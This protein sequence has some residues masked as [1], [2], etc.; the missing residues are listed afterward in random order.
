MKFRFLIPLVIILVVGGL[1]TLQNQRKQPID[2]LKQTP[3]GVSDGITGTSSVPVVLGERHGVRTR[4]LRNAKPIDAIIDSPT[5]EIPPIPLTANQK[6]KPTISPEDYLFLEPEKPSPPRYVALTLGNKTIQ[7][8]YAY[9]LRKQIK[10]LSG[11]E[12]LDVNSGLFYAFPSEGSYYF[13]MRGMLFSID[14]IWIGADGRVVD[15]KENLSP[16]TFPEK[17]TSREAAKYVLEVSAGF[18]KRNNISVGTKVD[19]SK[20]LNQ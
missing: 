12:G 2:P 8:E 7:A 1:Y 15:L 20:F 11:R 18:A 10:G 16:D 9:D 17:F 6:K 4:S 19:L 3:S 5:D 14:I 13:W